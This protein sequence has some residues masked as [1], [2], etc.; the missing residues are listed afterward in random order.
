M[1]ETKLFRLT[2]KDAFHT[3]G[4]YVF[5]HVGLYSFAFGAQS[6][7]ELLVVVKMILNGALVA[8]GDKDQRVNARSNGFFSGVLDQRLVHDGQ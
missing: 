3:C 1:A 4:Q 6:H 2:N 5:D 8:A 7:F